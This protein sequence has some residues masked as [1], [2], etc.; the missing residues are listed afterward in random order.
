M[1]SKERVM[2]ALAG[3][4]PD[5]VPFAESSIAPSIAKSLAGTERDLTEWEI[6]DMLDRDVV[7]PVLFPPYFADFEE[8]TDGQAYVT[9]G[10]IKTINDLDKMELPDPNDPSLYVDVVKAIENKGDYAVATAIKLGVAPML[11][12]MGLDGFSYAL[13]DEPDLVH[14]VLRRY[15][16]WQCVVSQKLIELGVD[17]LWSFD[18]IAYK[19]GLFCSEK[20]FKE[21]LFPYLQQAAEAITIPW[22]FHSDGNIMSV[23]DD[24]L[25][26]GMSGLHPIEPGPMDLAT[27]K[28]EYGKKV[29]VIGNVSVDT[30]S[31]GNTGDIDKI[32]KESIEIAG[33]GGGYMVTSSNSVPSYAKPEN[34]RAMADAV[35]KYGKYD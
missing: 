22:V 17:F 14:E 7:V 21:F 25:G 27:I 28:S 4:Q 33:P 35:Q 12:S 29:C 13:L 31:A 30:L 34:V 16:D 15:A 2:C 3:E 19:S 5:R 11:M 10:W 23:I 26:L 1:N 24:L 18:D 20:V 6:S 8:G 9:T 32:V